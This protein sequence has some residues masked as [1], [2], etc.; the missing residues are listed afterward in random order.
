MRTGRL[1]RSLA[2]L[3]VALWSTSC[4]LMSTPRTL[5]A[6][7]VAE[8]VAK[9][10][11]E[12][13]KAEEK[14]RLER[15]EE[16]K[17]LQLFADTL[18]QVE[19]NYVK[20]IS[21][22]ELMEAAIK[23]VISKL[24]Q[25]SNYIP[26][27]ELDRFKSGVESE[28]GGIG[29][30]VSIEDGHLKIISPIVGSPAHRAGLL[31]GDEITEIE[32]KATKG[33]TLDEAVKQMKGKIGTSVN[34][35]VKHPGEGKTEMVTLKR[36][37]IRVE[38]VMGDR[39]NEDGSWDFMLDAEKKLGYIRINSFS[40]HTT[41]ELRD[42]LR[43][44][45]KQDMT[46]L[47]VDL[48]FNPGGLLTTAI[49]VC[50]LFIDSGRI[51]STAGRNTPTRSWD[52]HKAGTFTGFPIAMLVNHYSASASEI[53]S[54]CLQ[55]HQRAVIIGERTWGKGSV[56]NIIELEDGKSALKL[57]T[58]G[59]QRPSGKN[60]HRFEG[61]GNNDEWGVKPNDG[62]EVKLSDAEAGEYLKY[63]RERDIVKG[64]V[65][66]PATAEAV[67]PFV[68]PQLKRAVEYLDQ[69]LAKAKEKP[70]EKPAAAEAETDATQAKK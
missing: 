59:Y 2:F 66:D 41:D 37:I 51:V 12:K 53:A 22:R 24:D 65:K 30:Q 67:K 44:L 5:A 4:L 54:A 61:A 29:I 68:D 15:E 35:T 63:R 32:G 8:Q 7:P 60:I 31:A 56:Q 52:A 34:I 19:R 28:F 33:I 43:S 58:S 11:D 40:R 18:D 20:D 21:R 39:R 55:D 1:M 45:Q 48:R 26:P 42:A 14:V 3:F 62:F 64:E 27:E 13:E 10:A 38:T 50:D 23:G 46:A 49:E 25:Y 57:T 16:L 70:E 17:L 6:D 36:E 69:Q 9:T 47:I